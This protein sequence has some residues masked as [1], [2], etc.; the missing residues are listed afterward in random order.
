VQHLAVTC[1]CPYGI[2][3]PASLIKVDAAMRARREQE[4]LPVPPA[5]AS[6][7]RPTESLAGAVVTKEIP[8][9]LHA[10]ERAVCR[11]FVQNTGQ[12]TWVAPGHTDGVQGVESSWPS[13][14][15][16]PDT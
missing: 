14:A 4:V 13:V 9:A 1:S 2:D 12:E 7:H 11:V 6:E 10:L 3:I 8:H 15:G 16:I 5:L